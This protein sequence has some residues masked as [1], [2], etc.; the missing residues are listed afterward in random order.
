MDIDTDKIDKAVLG[1]PPSVVGMNPFTRK[2]QE[3]FAPGST[4]QDLLAADR[5]R[6]GQEL[7]HGG[8]AGSFAESTSRAHPFVMIPHHNTPLG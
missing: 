7:S 2:P 6:P 5:Y 8:P 3:F 1:H 4:G